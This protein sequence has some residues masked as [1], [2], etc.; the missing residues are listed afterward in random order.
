MQ[1]PLAGGQDLLLARLDSQGSFEPSAIT[2][3]GPAD[4]HGTA[5]LPLADGSILLAGY[6]RGLGEGGEDAFVLRLTRP[7]FDRPNAAFKREVAKTP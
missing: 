4:D 6:S 7:A 2:I 3:G 1:Q 5:L